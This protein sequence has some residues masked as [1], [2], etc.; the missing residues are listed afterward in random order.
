MN[1]QV[2]SGSNGSIF[3]HNLRAPVPRSVFDKSYIHTFSADFGELIPFYLEDVLPNDDFKL[4][5]IIR[6]STL[7][8]VSPI[9]NAVKIKTWYFYVPYYL[10]WRHFDR[11][12]SGGR[13]GTYDVT[14]PIIGDP[15]TGITFQ[16]N[17]IADYFNFPVGVSIPADDCP[18]AFPFMAYQRIYRDYFFNQDVQTESNINNWFPDDDSKF[19]LADGFQSSIT[20][21]GE[22][23]VDDPAIDLTAKRFKNW[24]KD[25]FTSCMFNPQRGPATAMPITLT[26]Q[27][28]AS[29]Y[30]FSNV[31]S[32]RLDVDLKLL[33]GSFTPY[34]DNGYL[35]IRGGLN[36]ANAE[37]KDFLASGSSWPASATDLFYLQ[38]RGVLNPSFMGRFTD[39]SSG[40]ERYGSFGVNT[41]E[42]EMPSK[43]DFDAYL[44][45]YMS[46][47][48]KPPELDDM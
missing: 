10:L 7:P 8:M 35:G 47:I 38:S 1:N 21:T 19:Q 20:P 13:D 3:S 32:Q 18:S 15:S 45:A 23:S 44:G 22:S 5:N 48:R 43:S 37:Q 16:K 29:G 2:S 40:T 34:A 9:Y 14:P 46:S 41:P 36:L 33:N 4:S 26:G 6:V 30:P 39:I 11:F 17:S 24:E 42:I 12:I 31:D 25:Y 27:G 28:P